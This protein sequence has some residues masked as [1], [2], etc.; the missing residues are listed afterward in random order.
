VSLL[1]NW[2]DK[3]NDGILFRLGLDKAKVMAMHLS[4]LMGRQR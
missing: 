1:S 2:V 3:A 4:R